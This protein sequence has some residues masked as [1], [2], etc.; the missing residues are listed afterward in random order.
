MTLIHPG[1]IDTPYN[2]HARS[3][4]SKQPAHR[5]MIYPPEAVA[6]AILY[7]AEHQKRNM[8]VGTLVSKL[9]SLLCWVLWRHDLWIS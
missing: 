7:S 8:Y 1:R 5:G 3:Y 2:E 9:N 6:E 4:I